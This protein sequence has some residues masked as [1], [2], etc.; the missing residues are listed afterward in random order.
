MAATTTYTTYEQIGIREDLSNAIY[1]ISPTDTPAVSAIQKGA[2]AKNRFI[3]WQ[4]DALPTAAVN[5]NT[6]GA[7]VNYRTLTPTARLRNYTQ[8]SDDGI[9]ISGTSQAVTTAGREEE[10]AYQITQSGAWIKNC[11]EVQVTGNYASAVGTNATARRSAGI[12]AWITSN[13]SRGSGGADGGYTAAGTVTAA[14]DASSTNQRTFTETRLKAAIKDCWSSGGDPTLVIVGPV[15]KQK[16]SAFAGISTKFQ[17]FGANPQSGAGL[18]IIAAADFYV[19]DFGKHK[20]VPDR[21]SRE[22]TALVLDPKYWSMHNL[23]PFQVNAMAKTG[24]ADKKQLLVE[25]TLCSRN[26]AASA[27]VADLTTT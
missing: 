24:D 2:P 12:E 3:E 15:N 4:T 8:I 6:E 14:T 10:M 27:T 21:F 22:R 20:I 25:W 1:Q 23:R 26:Q 17:D 7:D 18:A 19:S 13:G 11:M 5:F 9:K 16:A